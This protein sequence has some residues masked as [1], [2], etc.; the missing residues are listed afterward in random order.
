[1]S[2]RRIEDEPQE[3]PR[4]EW[5]AVL[6]WLDRR[7]HPGEHLSIYGRTGSGKTYTIV[8]GLL[9]L[10]T[11]CRVLIIDVKHDQGTMAPVGHVVSRRPELSDR[12]SFKVR[13][14]VQGRESKAWDRDPEWYK[15]QPQHHRWVPDRKQ[16]TAHN[17]RV[18]SEIGRALDMAFHEGNWVIVVDDVVTV[19]DSKPPNL[20]L[21]D[22][23]QRIWRDGRDRGVTM[24]A[25]TQAPSYAPPAMYD[26]ASFAIFSRM[27]DVRRQERLGEIAGN[28]D[29]IEAELPRL[30]RHEILIGDLEYDNWVV[31]RVGDS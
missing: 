13:E 30:Q 24:I 23:L 16:Q 6:E 31:T 29:L 1:M 25:A 28:V 12:L 15:L 19:A 9:P 10:W 4:A 18:R 20:D 27:T 2:A 14:Y 11:R 21:A 22:L 3:I 5:S 7:W 8:H 17:D 26:Q